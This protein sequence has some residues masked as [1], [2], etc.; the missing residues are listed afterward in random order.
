MSALINDGGPAFPHHET[1][2][3]GEPY[4]DHLGMSLRDWFAGHAL[5][6]I[7][8]LLAANERNKSVEQIASWA[9]QVAD[10]MLA[11]RKEAQ[12]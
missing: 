2:S 12:Q 11:A 3:T 9:Y 10:A 5:G 6:H 1:T 4:H 8:A 7:P